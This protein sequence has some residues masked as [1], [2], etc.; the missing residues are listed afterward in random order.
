M[1]EKVEMELDR[2]MNILVD[3]QVYERESEILMNLLDVIFEN[4]TLGYKDQLQ[5][6]DYE[7]NII[8]FL[9]AVEPDLYEDR[10]Q[11]LLAEIESE[12]MIV[13]DL[14]NS[15]YPCPKPLDKKIT[16]HKQTK[17][18]E[19]SQKIK[20]E[21]WNRDNKRCIF[22]GKIVAKSYA[23]CHFIPRSAGGLGIAENIFTACENCHREQDNG[24]NTK[25]YDRKAKKYLKGIY[26]ASWKV[27]KLIYKKY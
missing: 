26:G 15:F 4:C 17:A 16:K 20:E 14:S 12:K 22:C 23:C 11:K 1:E 8:N 6:S 24:K 19:I 13:N 9:K 21:V 10:R 5:L 7:G 25:E 27:E 2:F 3:S 18:T